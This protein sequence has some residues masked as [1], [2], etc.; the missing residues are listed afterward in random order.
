MS[1]TEVQSQTQVTT[2]IGGESNN[3]ASIQ[4]LKELE[5]KELKEQSKKDSKEKDLKDQLPTK[6]YKKMPFVLEENKDI[7]NGKSLQSKVFSQNQRHPNGGWKF[8]DDV[9]LKKQ[10]GVCW[11]LVKS[12]GNSI[13]EGKE[14]VNTTL[15]IALFEARSFLEK[16]TDTWCY[17]PTY[18]NRAAEATDPVERLKYVISF[19]ISGLHLT[20]TLTKPFNPLLGETFQGSFADGTQVYSEQTS[21]HPPISH[22]Q[23]V[24]KDEKFHYHGHGIWSA[25]C[26]GNV[27]KGYQ[28][29]PHYIDFQDGTRISWT[30]PDI[31]IKGIFWGDRVTDLAGKIHF[32]DERNGLG[33]ATSS[34]SSESK[35][36]P[37]D[38]IN[39]CTIEGT[40]L[41]HLCFNDI[42]YWSL[43][44]V[45][46]GVIY[47]DN[48]L[49]T[50]CRFRD[51]LRYLKEGNIEKAKEYKALIEDK[52]RKEAKL[53]KDEITSADWMIL[54]GYLELLSY[55][56][57]RNELVSINP[58]TI[59]SVMKG[60]ND[61][62]IFLRLTELYPQVFQYP[63][64]RCRK[65][66]IESG[67]VGGS[68]EIVQWL[69]NR[70]YTITN[71]AVNL[72][73]RLGRFEILKYFQGVLKKEIIIEC[74]NQG[75]LEKFEPK[76]DPD[77]VDRAAENGHF[78]I[79]KYLLGNYKGGG[80]GVG[81]THKAIDKSAENGHLEIVKYL[82]ELCGGDRRYYTTQALLG[83]TKNGHIEVIR[84]FI[85]QKNV[86]KTYYRELL[87]EASVAGHMGLIR[88]LHWNCP[89]TVAT[90]MAM[91][92]S[93][94]CN[95][96]DILSFLHYNRTT[97]GGCSEKAFL[98]AASGGHLDVVRFLQQNRTEPIPVPGTIHEACSSGH[99]EVVA[100]LLD[101]GLGEPSRE[102]IKRGVFSKNTALVQYLFNR[103]P[104]IDIYDQPYRILPDTLLREAIP[105]G[106]YQMVKIIV[107]Q[108][109]DPSELNRSYHYI[110]S[111][112]LSGSID[113]VKLFHAAITKHITQIP[114]D[115]SALVM[116]ALK[117]RH[118]PMVDYILKTYDLEFTTAQLAECIS[119]NRE[120]TVQFIITNKLAV[121]DDTCFSAAFINFK[122]HD[123]I[124]FM[125]EQGYRPTT[126]KP[127]IDSVKY[128][129]S[130]F[131]YALK[132][133]PEFID[134][135]DTMSQILKG[136]LKRFD[137]L[138][139]IYETMTDPI[140]RSKYFYDNPQLLQSPVSIQ[141]MTSKG[142]IVDRVLNPN[143]DFP[144]TPIPNLF[145]PIP[146]EIL[147]GHNNFNTSNNNQNNNSSEQI[148]LLKSIELQPTEKEIED[149]KNGIRKKKV[150][151]PP[152]HSQ[153]DW[154]RKQ[155]AIPSPS[156]FNGHGKI[157]ITELKKHSTESDAWTVYK[158]KVYNITDYIIY[159]P[160][161]RD[162]LL[163]AA[164]S[165]CTRMFDLEGN[166]HQQIQY[167]G[168]YPDH[169][170]GHSCVL[171]E[172]STSIL[173]FG[174][175]KST[176]PEYSG[177]LWQY[178]LF[179]ATWSLLSLYT[180]P[181]IPD[182]QNATNTTEPLN[183]NNS[184]LT[185]GTSNN[186]SKMISNRHK[187]VKRDESSSN[188]DDD[189][190]VEI[191]PFPRY[192]H[193]STSNSTAMFIFGGLT[194][195]TIRQDEPELL[196][197]FW[198]YNV[199]NR[200]WTQIYK[201][202]ENEDQFPTPRY[203]HSMVYANGNLYMFGGFLSVNEDDPTNE[204][205]VFLIESSVWYLIDLDY[206]ELER[207]F[208]S[209]TL[210]SK[211]SRGILVYGGTRHGVTLSDLWVFDIDSESWTTLV[212]SFHS[213]SLSL[214]A[215]SISVDVNGIVLFGGTTIR[216]VFWGYSLNCDCN[217]R[218]GC[219]YGKCSCFSGYFGEYCEY[220][221]DGPILLGLG[222]AI[223]VPILCFGWCVLRC[224]ALP[225]RI[226]ILT[227][228]IIII[229]CSLFASIQSCLQCWLPVAIM[230]FLTGGG[231]L[232]GILKS[233][234]P[235]IM[236]YFSIA[237][238]ITIGA[239][240]Y[241]LVTF[242]PPCMMGNCK[243][244][245][246]GSVWLP[247]YAIIMTFVHLAFLILVLPL[248]LKL[249]KH[250]KFIDIINNNGG[251][252]GG[253]NGGSGLVLNND[254][255]GLTPLMKKID[256]EM[257]SDDADPSG[258]ADRSDTGT[259]ALNY[260][261]K[262]HQLRSELNKIRTSK[263]A[264][265]L[266]IRIDRRN[267]LE[268]S[269]NQLHDLSTNQIIQNIWVK[270][271][272]EEGVDMGGLRKEWLSLLF[273]QLFDPQYSLFVVNSNYT[274]SIN[275]NSHY[276][277]DHLSYFWFSGR[278]VAR[279]VTEGIHLD[280]TFSRTIYKMILGKPPSLD[281]LAYVDPEFHKSLVWILENS[282]EEM[283]EVT[284]ST[285][286]DNMGE[287]VLVDLKPNGREILVT[288]DNKQEFVKLILEWRLRR[289]ISDQSYHFVMGFRDVIPLNLISQF[290]E[291]ELELFI[292]GLVE[293]DIQDWKANTNYRGYNAT[294]SVIEWFWQI[295]EDMEQ[296]N[297]IRLLQFVTGNARLPPSG[298]QG[299]MSADGPLKFQI[300]KS[301]SPDNQLPVAR[302][303]FN[304]LDLPNYDSKEKLQHALYV[305]IQEGLPGFGLA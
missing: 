287:N 128:S 170:W 153:L 130:G 110:F 274:I 152:G 129:S 256:S 131:K 3:D 300:H 175:S 52:Q 148:E 192:F 200:V 262:E 201:T 265:E 291:C 215:A 179:N 213:P 141:F 206:P 189:K 255:T 159:H 82:W 191:F 60:L 227:L 80:D 70:Q 271:V 244:E 92:F 166:G 72:A 251:I 40:W 260:L 208:H 272:D 205:W 172:N 232:I 140:K 38:V 87:D 268:D 303:C 199:S 54:N 35:K 194:N 132:R 29:G 5:K 264:E 13:I 95:R 94:K 298:F 63:T 76:N 102:L 257:N 73:A 84:F 304:R 139:I 86:D 279:S 55:K 270:F 204:L 17:A 89:S 184:S 165:D 112:I 31:Y 195:K 212:G 299:L 269:Y 248:S 280:H 288:E 47:S 224:T 43:E 21:H 30:L 223:S 27:V 218:G 116:H 183:N 25:G 236:L 193:S 278:M 221:I 171:I 133:F 220:S 118:L 104:E 90:T 12:V 163:R 49:P 181:P 243:N 7:G 15:P 293:I 250:R 44:M 51:D 290:N 11:E 176:S 108:L 26:R 190:P 252:G 50:D 48:P 297:R 37:K 261:Q 9:E 111:A 14:L 174:G 125:L 100:Y 249:Y 16:L 109:N 120:D 228:L 119:Q 294:S 145:V 83:A 157:T 186:Y 242:L 305:A 93:A 158:G 281:D 203:G 222:L 182:K 124:E 202:P 6:V 229:S 219:Y 151:L 65:Y 46:S 187:R 98:F 169:R 91:D 253:G 233:K 275:P 28:K 167:S 230:G 68:L 266:R 79:V 239:N 24:G 149:K 8:I 33:G 114:N 210:D 74:V 168:F 296:E 207:G 39:I 4:K 254:L 58:S 289:D 77:L 234:K 225:V 150:P 42:I 301:Y 277:Q 20:S 211:K 85:Q 180:P 106:D 134:Q 267:V 64:P 121:V 103:N 238:C 41:T 196:G 217:G 117:S 113:I 156:L 286:F 81:F 136:A 59:V 61:Y 142:Y 245:Q 240:I 263:S 1:S 216:D 97:D 283:E 302:T 123:I 273:K 71:E 162:E 197:D 198:I 67:V 105:T 138:D 173:V 282:V 56:L 32:T 177:E 241:G 99:I 147:F 259:K 160:G 107:D 285:T 237:V 22:W 57:S 78:N 23:V 96:I 2:I 284:F 231:G 155:N 88:Y 143:G 178:N 276:Q 292:C 246:P 101:H 45:P 226:K 36:K 19:T 126:N 164:G 53:R 122:S 235:K 146:K 188:T 69:A 18:L 66:L 258:S 209:M 75:I 127:L 161:G 214:S 34:K 137:Q 10:R 247:K 154:M 62:S 185:A 144:T 295:V 135:P 115:K